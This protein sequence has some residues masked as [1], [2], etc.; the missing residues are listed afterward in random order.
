M[1]HA[2]SKFQ[3]TA[4]GLIPRTYSIEAHVARAAIVWGNSESIKPP[5]PP[6]LSPPRGKEQFLHG[7]QGKSLTRKLEVEGMT[8]L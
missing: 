4:W 6:S 2:N 3:I 1:A 8:T 7:A 5:P